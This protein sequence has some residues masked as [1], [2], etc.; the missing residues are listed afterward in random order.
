VQL[1]IGGVSIIVVSYR[2]SNKVEP[3]WQ[4][5]QPAGMSAMG[6]KQTFGS[7]GKGVRTPR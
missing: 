6:R 5:L 3:H 2:G 7:G 1:V 4:S